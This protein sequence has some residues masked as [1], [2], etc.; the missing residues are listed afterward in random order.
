MKRKVLLALIAVIFLCTPL[1]ALTGREIMEK[2]DALPEPK[3]ADSTVLMNIY[4]GN[5][6][7]EKEF[8]MKAKKM[9]DDEDAIIISFIRPTQITLLTHT[10]KVQD[11][12]Q[13]LKLSSGKVKR[14]ASTDKDKPF[15]NSHF[16]YEDLG[17]RDI[18]KFD[19]TLLGEGKAVGEDCYKVESVKNR[20]TKVYDKM[21]LYVRKSDY[22]IVRIDFFKD[23][24]F[25][26]YMENYDI[27]KVKNILTPFKAV[28][29][30]ADGA[31]KTELIMEKVDYNMDMKSS[32]FD[33]EALR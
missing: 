7:L 22:F 15:V 9:K 30:L 4:K 24:E 14:I 26:K 27:K 10:Y 25:H 21:I 23:G 6:V 19:F 32:L 29:S 5:D 1:W 13:W 20:G 11:D 3:T 31:G 16:Y 33:K 8:E 28:M 12:D 17:S 2:S 18:D